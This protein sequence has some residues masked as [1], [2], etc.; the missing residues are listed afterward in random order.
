MN[1]R[2]CQRGKKPTFVYDAN[3]RHPPENQNT[4]EGFLV[5]LSGLQVEPAPVAQNENVRVGMT[6]LEKIG[7]RYFPA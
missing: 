6:T 3:M 5:L 4:A 2:N 1:A 7:A